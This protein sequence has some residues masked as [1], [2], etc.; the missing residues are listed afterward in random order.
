MTSSSALS[1]DIASESFLAHYAI[2][3]EFFFFLFQFLFVEATG[4]AERLIASEERAAEDF[5]HG[6]DVDGTEQSERVWDQLEVLATGV[7]CSRLFRSME[8]R[9]SFLSW[10]QSGVLDV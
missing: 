6:G 9:F 10:S 5:L 4:F 2:A 1:F 7:T 8:L 3:V